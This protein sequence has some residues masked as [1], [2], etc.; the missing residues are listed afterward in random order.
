MSINAYLNFQGNTREVV[1]FYAEVFNL[2]TPKIITFGDMP[3]HPDYPLPEEAK[4][5]V[6]HT[7]LDING[8]PLMFSDVF[9]GMPYVVGNNISLS[10]VSSNA[11][12]IQ[13]AFH[14]LKEGGKIGMELQA[15]DWSKLYGQV[16]DKFGILWQFNLDSGE[17]F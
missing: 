2:P 12:E 13:N 7:R 14:K 9:P 6:M 5:G 4:N 8:S 1:T 3:A 15:T 16:E 10:Y 17:T 11:E